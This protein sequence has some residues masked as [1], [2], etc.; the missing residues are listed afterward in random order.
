MTRKHKTRKNKTRKKIIGGFCPFYK[1]ERVLS[2]E[3]LTILQNLGYNYTKDICVY[4]D[5]WSKIFNI[6]QNRLKIKSN[7][8]TFN[9]ENAQAKAKANANKA[10]ANKAKAN[11]KVNK[12]KANKA[13]A[14]KAMAEQYAYLSELTIPENNK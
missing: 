11:A 3:E 13:K 12:A 9:K 1:I 14:N 10:K 4:N 2:D 7:R 6:I 5:E 8:I